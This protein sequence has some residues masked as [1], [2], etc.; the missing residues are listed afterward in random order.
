MAMKKNNGKI[1]Y[2][3]LGANIIYL[4]LFYCFMNYFQL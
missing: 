4:F 2:I 3:L 1:Y